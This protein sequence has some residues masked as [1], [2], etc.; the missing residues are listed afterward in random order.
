M[1]SEKVKYIGA[2][3]RFSCD[4]MPFGTHPGLSKGPKLMNSV[5]GEIR[6]LIEA[7]VSNAYILYLAKM[8]DKTSCS[9]KCLIFRQLHQSVLEHTCIIA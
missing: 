9:L 4:F 1:E 3:L 8:K 5:I 6:N 7:K 2:C